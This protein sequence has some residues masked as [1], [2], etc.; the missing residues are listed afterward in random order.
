[1]SGVVNA[2]DYVPGVVAGSIA[3]VFGSNLA[4]GQASSTAPA[5]LPTT[6]AQSSLMIGTQAMPLYVAMASQVNVQIPW[7]VAGQTQTSITATVN[8]VTS[9]TE[10][11]PLVNFA[12][13]I[14]TT[15][16][17]GTGQGA[18]L[19]AGTAQLAS[20]GT[21]ATRGGYVSIFCTGLGAVSNQPATGTAALVNPL[22][23][24]SASAGVA[25]GG[26]AATV[27]FSGLAPGFVGLYQVNAQVPTSISAGTV[28]VVLSIGNISSNSVT[29]V[30]Q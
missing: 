16:M 19:I 24:T 2:A 8:G 21:P 12:P 29:I 20:A 7:E 3:A 17:L 22:S 14:F 23:Q 28:T 10:I 9:N 4:I 30:V 26:T 15:N 13:G 5:P 18:I 25:I 1:V 27:T 11:T 6:L